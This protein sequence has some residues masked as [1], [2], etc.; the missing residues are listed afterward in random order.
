[1]KSDNFSSETHRPWK[2]RIVS[3]AMAAGFLVFFTVV[4]VIIVSSKPEPQKAE[5][6]EPVFSVRAEVARFA[7]ARP[8]VLLSGEV[9]ARD[10]A[11]L[12]APVEAE[13]RKIAVREG[14]TFT[15]NQRL[16]LLDLREQQLQAESRRTAVE[17][18]RLQIAALETNQSAD[19]RRLSETENLLNLASRDYDR[20]IT[21]QAKNLVSRSRI[22]SA[23]QLVS[24]RRQEFI[25]LQNKVDNY[26][27]EKQRLQQQLAAA[28]VELKQAELLI[29]RG[30]IRAPFPGRVARV[31]VSAGARTSRG[32]PLVEV[33]NPETVRLRAVVPNRYAPLLADNGDAR[34]VLQRGA[35]VDELPVSNLSP[36]AGS[37]QGGVEAFFNLPA[38]NWVLGATY[39]F[40]LELPPAA[41]AVELPFDAV[42]GEARIYRIDDEDRARGM[43]CVRLGVARENNEI[44]AL[45]RCPDIHE[46]D[47]VVA[48]QLPGMA[49]GAKVR[50]L[51][52]K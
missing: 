7:A 19:Q 29:E 23:E 8:S 33:F 14:E 28:E 13:V 48:T 6:R 42:Y 27:L 26:P 12:T 34:A 43:E 17:S 4:A 16:V 15:D 47:Q 21:L 5:V 10:Y 2:T 46:G 25:S 40:R 32:Q 45:L 49:E 22:E 35:Q 18:A 9:E 44:R 52:A 3:V 20:N 1:M 31:P 11:V 39:E 50:V 41:D 38:D 30:E 24:Q 37:G 36:R 51:G